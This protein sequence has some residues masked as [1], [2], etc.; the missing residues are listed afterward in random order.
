MVSLRCCQIQSFIWECES[1]EMLESL[2]IRI[3]LLL[4]FYLFEKVMTSAQLNTKM[5]QGSI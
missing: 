2:E 3:Y 5:L 1:A 4:L